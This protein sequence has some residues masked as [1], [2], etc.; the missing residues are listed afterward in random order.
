MIQSNLINIDYHLLLILRI[1]EIMNTL[2]VDIL[3]PKAGKLLKDLASLGLIEIRPLSD[4]GFLKVVE[5]IRS[6]A[7]KDSPS[8]EEITAEVELVRTKRYGKKKR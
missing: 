3:N 1:F 8:L 2:Q 7:K 6:K 4:D 5:S